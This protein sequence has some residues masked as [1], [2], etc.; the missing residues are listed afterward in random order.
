MPLSP[1]LAES[2]HP[3]ARSTTA[4]RNLEEHIRNLVLKGSLK[5]GELLGTEGELSEHYG[6]SRSVVREA[7]KRLQAV[8]IVELRT[9]PGGGARVC[10]GNAAFF[11]DALAVQLKLIGAS[12]KETVAAQVAVECM[13]VELAAHH[14]GEADLARLRELV[15]EAEANLGRL[16]ECR[17]LCHEFHSVLT[18]AS[19]NRVLTSMFGSL[20]HLRNDTLGSFPSRARAQKVIREHREL[21]KVLARRDAAGARRS[22]EKHL[23]GLRRLPSGRATLD[24]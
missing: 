1:Q 5:P 11:A 9:G 22:M 17:R 16:D 4:S 15:A 18:G 2:D 20:Q 6:M 7:L 24:H 21:L 12:Q 13:S 3:I 14:A 23:Q 10:Q 8:G 19:K